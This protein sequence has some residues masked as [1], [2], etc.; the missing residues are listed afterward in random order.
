M[1]SP[2]ITPTPV[3]PVAPVIQAPNPVTEHTRVDTIQNQIA[4]RLA[5]ARPA[6]NPVPGMPVNPVAAAPAIAAVIPAVVPPVVAPATPV[7][8]DPNAPAVILPAVDPDIDLASLD[9]DAPPKPDTPAEPL[10]EGVTAPVTAPETDSLRELAEVLA[11]GEIPEKV[12]EV[13]LR[14]SRGK[15]MLQSFKALRDLAQAPDKGGIGRVPTMEEIREADNSHRAV[16]AMRDEYANDPL[17]FVNNLFVPNSETGMTFLGDPARA[18]QV[19]EAIPQALFNAARSTNNPVYGQMIVAYSAPVFQ[20]FFDHQYNQALQM[21]EETPAVIAQYRAAK[22]DPPLLSDKIRMIDALQ[23]SEFK[24]FGKPRPMNWTPGQ[25][26][27]QPVNGA[28]DPEKQQLMDRIKAQDARIQ[29][30]N[31]RQLSNVMNQVESGGRTAAMADVEFAL[32]HAGVDKVYPAS[33]IQSQQR[34]IYEDLK[35]AMPSHDPSGWQR[36]QIQLKDAANGRLD[37]TVAAKTFRSLFQNALRH[38]PQVRERLNDL[39]KGAKTNV[40]AQHQ[41]RL[42]SQLR[43]EPNGTGIPAPSS[44]LAGQQLAR[45]SGESIEDFNTRRILAARQRSVQAPAR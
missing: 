43:T 36:Y 20:N 25:P 44:V 24:A 34:D 7:V 13:F 18:S 23:L 31:Q 14:T 29:S 30:D 17:S 2:V 26:S 40:D 22:Q 32:K 11:K 27:T 6:P 1:S 28:P 4:A 37:P 35:T 45:Q 5:A 39:V 8:T 19:L 12:E 33:V 10:P 16:T 15:Q 3:I 41:S 38:S 21:P 42:Q 9:F